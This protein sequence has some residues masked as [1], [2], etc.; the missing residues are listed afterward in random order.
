MSTVAP[1]RS[2]SQSDERPEPLRR[3]STPRPAAIP[4]A[5]GRRLLNYVLV[6]VTIVLVL[7]ALVGDKGLTETLRAR[8]QYAQVAASLADLRQQ[9]AKLRDQIHRLEEDP[10]TIESIAREELGLMRPGELLVIV[11]DDSK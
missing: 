9:N 5:L 4:A 3:R 2:R 1:A 11:H 8:R 6:L 10:A 7:D